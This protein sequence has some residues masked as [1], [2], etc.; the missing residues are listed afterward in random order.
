MTHWSARYVGLP[1]GDG[2]G[3]VT[4][5]SLVRRVYAQEFGID[6][7]SYGEISSLDLLRV[8]RAMADGAAGESWA[9]VAEPKEGDIC[10]MRSARGGSAIVHVGVMADARNLLHVE[11]AKAAVIVPLS[12]F[13]VATRIAGWRRRVA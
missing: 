6:L 13:S 2:P 1:F 8:A 9:A 4:C 12:H 7:P 3:Q 5:W 10:L 11:E